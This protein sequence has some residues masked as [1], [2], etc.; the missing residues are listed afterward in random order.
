MNYK[1]R[2]QIFNKN[3]Q[4]NHKKNLSNSLHII[5]KLDNKKEEIYDWKSGEDPFNLINLIK[6][7]N[8]NNLSENSINLIYQKIINAINY[9]KNLLDLVP[10]NY[11]LKKMNIIKNVLIE[12]EKNSELKK[13][14]E[15]FLN[16][17]NSF[18]EN[19]NQYEKYISEIKPNYNDLKEIDCLNITQ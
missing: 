4:L 15:P 11:T 1:N 10:S 5:I 3:N 17:N 16:K 7:N 14:F 8:K 2:N 18:L 13:H 6:N 12:R 19:R 9:S